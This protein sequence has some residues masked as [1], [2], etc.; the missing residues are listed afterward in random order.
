MFARLF[1]CEGEKKL[2]V[3]GLVFVLRIRTDRPL[4]L[5]L[6]LCERS[7]LARVS[8]HEVTLRGAAA[9]VSGPPG[10]GSARSTKVRSA[11]SSSGKRRVASRI[12][13]PE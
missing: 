11:Y 4:L 9:Y 12:R 1:L 6:F 13:T 8:K 3:G 7:H 10:V 5:L 2:L